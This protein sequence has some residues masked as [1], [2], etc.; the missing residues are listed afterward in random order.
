[1]C[2]AL[3]L[4]DPQFVVVVWVGGVGQL[5]SG[6][7]IMKHARHASAHVILALNR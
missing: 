6:P 3:V 4:E 5:L 1:M 2:V 7:W